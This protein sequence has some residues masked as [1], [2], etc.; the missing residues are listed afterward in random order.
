M[1]Y[2]GNILV[3]IWDLII[4]VLHL[5]HNE[6]VINSFTTQQLLMCALLCHAPVMNDRYD[7][8][9]L[10]RGQSMCDNDGR[11]SLTSGVQSL[12]DNLSV[13]NEIKYNSHSP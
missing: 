4:L 13:I 10:H 12:L 1:E 9:V 7:V 5:R 3:T 2:I 8:S 11:A 6:I